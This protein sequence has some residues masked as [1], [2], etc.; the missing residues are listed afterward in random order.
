MSDQAKIFSYKNQ[1]RI[2]FENAVAANITVIAASV[3][4]VVLMRD[5]PQFLQSILWM[6]AI[7]FVCILRI[8]V[9][10]G[11][12][13]SFDLSVT[14]WER[15]YTILTL[16]V[17]I[18]WGSLSF[19]LYFSDQL[20]V[21][22]LVFMLVIGAITASVPVL[23][24]VLRSFYA[25][26]IP[27]LV[28]LSVALLIKDTLFYSVIA[29]ML[30]IYGGLI[31]KLANNTNRHLI[32][33][34]Q[35]QY[36][37]EV[38]ITELNKEVGEREDAQQKL[39]KYGEDLEKIVDERTRQ[40][41]EI[42]QSLKLE[43]HERKRAQDDLNYLAH[44]DAVTNLPNR[45][46]LN[47]RLEHSI[48]RAKRNNTLVAVLF[49]DL[50]NFKHINDS[51]G[52]AFGDSI[53]RKVG[54]RFQHCSREDDTVA[55]QGGDEFI[56]IIE[57]PKSE[58]M[59]RVFAEKIISELNKEFE[60]QHHSLHISTSIGISIYPSDGDTTE[61]LI[62]Y[63]DAAM[64]KSKS[65]GR[66]N[67][68]FYTPDLTETAFDRVVLE[69][70]LRKALANRELTVYYQPQV[71]LKSGEV[72]AVEALVRWCHPDL[73]ILTPEHFLQ[74]AE[75]SGLIM[76]LGKFV[77]ETAC[78]QMSIWHETG[79]HI[80]HVAVNVS[81]LQIDD[82]NFATS[83]EGILEKTK[84]KPQWLELEITESCIM[85]ESEKSVETLD[86]LRGLGV[87]FAIDDFGTGYSSLSH[88]K[89]LPVDTLKIDRCF[90]SD[91]ESDSSDLAIVEAI[92][93]LANTL[94][95]IVTAEGIE[96]YAHEVR[97]KELG[98]NIGQGFY[99]SRP[100]PSED[101]TT[102]I[103]NPFIRH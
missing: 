34:F 81:G 82:Y 48:Q 57:E 22:V 19:F 55:R 67:F 17:G 75:D 102:L 27:M 63:A 31:I 37:N 56:I 94:Q 30:I 58:E 72:I 2:I 15:I 101:L 83:V 16:I 77:L 21:Q 12:F 18:I 79:I 44:Y 92:I 42:N 9:R 25:Y 100:I 88:L 73:G 99:Y 54:E 59:I 29:I 87:R 69:G 38:L 39:K 103:V 46:L 47:V 53:L 28:G 96:S 49:L 41:V 33:S 51:F 14:V 62:A 91:I 43:I 66:N 8:F 20:I 78:E 45:L 7:S 50:D 3:F 68:Q 13:R 74:I 76:P 98:C 85:K 11:Y 70:S 65:E 40:L 52:H 26:I 64:Y 36:R 90:I 61:K 5:Y 95:L 89:R 80:R 86:Y 10:Y 23:S 6:I 71:S 60:V 24:S 93:A 32:N 35:L 97:L 4:F 84:C 1:V